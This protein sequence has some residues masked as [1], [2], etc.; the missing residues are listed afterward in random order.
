MCK[1]SVTR[2]LCIILVDEGDVLCL[3]SG[4][5][6]VQA[7]LWHC[8][9]KGVTCSHEDSLGSAPCLQ[10]CGA[11]SQQRGRGLSKPC[12][13]LCWQNRNQQQNLFCA[14]VWSGYCL[15]VIVLI[16]YF[17]PGFLIRDQT[18]RVFFVWPVSVS[19]VSSFSLSQPRYTR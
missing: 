15:K 4:G 3:L 9:R 8:G 14:F 11:A 19:K 17:F 2:G 1:P 12:T 10:R 7:P 16:H 18:V 6:D 5:E 13:Q